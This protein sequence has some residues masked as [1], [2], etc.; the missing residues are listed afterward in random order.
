MALR[1]RRPCPGLSN[2]CGERGASVGRKAKGGRDADEAPPPDRP[3]RWIPWESPDVLRSLDELLGNAWAAWS[4][5]V[6]MAPHV[7]DAPVVA[8]ILRALR[9]ARSL[10]NR[11]ALDLLD[12]G[13]RSALNC[14]DPEIA[15]RTFKR[16]Q[17]EGVQLAP[18]VTA[19]HFRASRENRRS[20]RNSDRRLAV[21]SLVE[22]MDVA[23]SRPARGLPAASAA[24]LARTFSIRLAHTEPLA[25]ELKRLEIIRVGT[26]AQL[27]D[28]TADSKVAAAFEDV[29]SPTDAA[30]VATG[31]KLVRAGLRA[32]GYPG[33]ENLLE[34]SRKRRRRA[35]PRRRAPDE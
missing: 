11:D 13:A 8:R 31:E 23:L 17:D 30:D 14:M 15:T 21:D 22:Q 16:Y 10:G 24:E 9:E 6:D 34:A 25:H 20:G 26:A 32:L 27:R 33:A 28:A 3:E 2:R 18:G 4:S 7:E 1:T 12:V 5:A 35:A 29:L 19:D